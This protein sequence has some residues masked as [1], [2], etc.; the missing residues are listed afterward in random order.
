M[1]ISSEITIVI[2]WDRSA[3]WRPRT[4]AHAYKG[5]LFNNFVSAQILRYEQQVLVERG[6]N[7]R[8]VLIVAEHTFVLRNA[9]KYREL[10]KYSAYSI[11]RHGRALAER[12]RDHFVSFD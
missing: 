12:D 5:Q 6:K 1:R 4:T 8:I 2:N 7:C 9:L 10:S 11:H 3:V